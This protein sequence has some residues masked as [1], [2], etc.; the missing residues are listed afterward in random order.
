MITPVNWGR[1]ALSVD[2]TFFSDTRFVV[3]SNYGRRYADC[4]ISFLVDEFHAAGH[5]SCAV[6]SSFAVAAKADPSLAHINSSAAEGGHWAFCSQENQKIFHVH[7]RSSLSHHAV[8]DDTN[9]QPL[10]YASVKASRMHIDKP[11]TRHFWQVC[12]Q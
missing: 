10:R 6:S 9:I 2:P 12:I 4:Y 7:G 8:H 3:I 5:T 11:L 1:N